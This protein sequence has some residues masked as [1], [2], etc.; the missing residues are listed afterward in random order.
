MFWE[1]LLFTKFMTVT[2]SAF[3]KKGHVNVSLFYWRF[4]SNLDIDFMV[5]FVI[6]LKE[7]ICIPNYCNVF[8]PPF[9]SWKDLCFVVPYTCNVLL[10]FIG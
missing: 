1:S 5:I 2:T 10:D 4:C 9:N 8:K 6:K 7:C 3:S